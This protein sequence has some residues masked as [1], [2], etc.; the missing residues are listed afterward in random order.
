MLFDRTDT[1]VV[2]DGLGTEIATAIGMLNFK[3]MGQSFTLDRVLLVPNFKRILISEGRLLSGGYNITKQERFATELAPYVSRVLVNEKNQWLKF[4]QEMENEH[5]RRRG[6]GLMHMK[7]QMIIPTKWED[8]CGCNEEIKFEEKPSI[9]ANNMSWWI[10]DCIDTGSEEARIDDI[11]VMSEEL[12]EEEYAPMSHV[13][14]IDD[15]T[16]ENVVTKDG[17]SI[18]NG[19]SLF[20]NEEEIIE[21][22]NTQNLN[23]VQFEKR[24]NK[25]GEITNELS[26]LIHS[27]W[28]RLNGKALTIVARQL[29]KLPYE[30]GLTLLQQSCSTCDSSKMTERGSIISKNMQRDSAVG[31]MMVDWMILPEVISR[32][33]SLQGY[34]YLFVAVM[35]DSLWLYLKGGRSRDNSHGYL[36]EAICQ[37]GGP[38]R[39]LRCDNEFDTREVRSLLHNHGI[40]LELCRERKRTL[41]YLA[42]ITVASVK[43]YVV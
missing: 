35:R 12:H 40:K 8:M 28:H 27:R 36:G 43:I 39:I 20:L 18:G 37:Y 11:M 19:S 22:E 5:G 15:G 4:I 31:T 24:K 23:V 41:V 29:L 42:L 14:L 21:K 2:I 32:E 7:V 33:H 26:Q 10:N 1:T 17:N 6:H 34:K 30:S 13:F 38:I 25:K 16:S 3:F 9:A